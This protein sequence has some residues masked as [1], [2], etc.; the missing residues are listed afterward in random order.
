MSG[1]LQKDL[2]AVSY[3]LMTLR[4]S[5]FVRRQIAA[6]TNL[7]SEP[8]VTYSIKSSESEEL[9]I[10]NR[11][12]P[13]CFFFFKMDV[14]QP[15]KRPAASPPAAGL[16]PPFQSRLTTLS[17]R[18]YLLVSF[19]WLSR[20]STGTSMKKKFYTDPKH[21]GCS[22]TLWANSE[23]RSWKSGS[24]ACGICGWHW[25]WRLLQPTHRSMP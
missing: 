2:S 1:P 16:L 20:V 5:E 14:D 24:W 9:Y 23:K 13:L 25:N 19:R 17:G 4:N 18:D 8:L 7:T 12:A 11:P 10:K 3:L 6:L 15:S 22:K 21:P